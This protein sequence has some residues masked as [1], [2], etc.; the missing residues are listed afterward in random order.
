MSLIL[1]VL[2]QPWGIT[3]ALELEM[4]RK[5]SSALVLSVASLEWA[6]LRLQ[7]S[8]V[9]QELG[10]LFDRISVDGLRLEYLHPHR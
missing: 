6:W 8:E 9:G 10:Q 5:V 2:I 3:L 4:L 7:I 1:A